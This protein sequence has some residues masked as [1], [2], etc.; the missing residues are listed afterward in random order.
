M[1]PEY[2]RANITIGFCWVVKRHK[3][4]HMMS[5]LLYRW[6]CH[7]KTQLVFTVLSEV[8]ACYQQALLRH[9]KRHIARS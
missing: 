5:C 7:L 3:E 4:K 6:I 2:L 8:Q 1:F 9:R